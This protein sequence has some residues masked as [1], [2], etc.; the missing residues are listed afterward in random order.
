M[1]ASS[2]ERFDYPFRRTW[3]TIEVHRRVRN[4]GSLLAL[5]RLDLR[6]VVDVSVDVC[7]N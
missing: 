5:R 2:R 3:R 6:G 7:A 1:L 4:T